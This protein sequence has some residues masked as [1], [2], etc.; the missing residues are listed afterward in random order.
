LIS[1]GFGG[2][3][4]LVRG[5]ISAMRQY[6]PDLVDKLLKDYNSYLDDPNKIDLYKLQG[7][8]KAILDISNNPSLAQYSQTLVNLHQLAYFFNVA[9]PNDDLIKAIN[10]SLDE[11]KTAPIP[12]DQK[13]PDSLLQF[14]EGYPANRRTLLDDVRNFG[15]LIGGDFKPPA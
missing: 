15:T 10:E 9:F 4:T 7:T 8:G 11:L 5:A 3:P 12:P 14:P 2:D 1:Q 13:I 6:A